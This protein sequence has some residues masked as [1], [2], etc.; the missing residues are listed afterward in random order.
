MM[1]TGYPAMAN[2]VE[3]KIL[4][5][6]FSEADADLFLKIEATP[7]TIQQVA[8]RVEADVADMPKNLNL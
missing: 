3:L 5:Q 4:R 8:L 1:A 7:E 6:L 2:G